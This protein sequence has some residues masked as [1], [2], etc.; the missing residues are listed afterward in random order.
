MSDRA[1]AI[2]LIVRMCTPEKPNEDQEGVFSFW[3]EFKLAVSSKAAAVFYALRCGHPLAICHHI[4]II[5]PCCGLAIIGKSLLSYVLVVCSCG[6]VVCCIVFVRLLCCGYNY[7]VKNK[8]G[9]LPFY[10]VL[11]KSIHRVSSSSKHILSPSTLSVTSSQTK[12]W[13]VV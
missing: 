12:G 5:W 11:I 3:P 4:V 8:N 2:T 6:L 7:A 13:M 9:K 1:D 10:G